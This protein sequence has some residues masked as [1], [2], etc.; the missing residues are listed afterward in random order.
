MYIPCLHFLSHIHVIVLTT[1]GY[2]Y[3]SN[4]SPEDGGSK[5][6]WNV[7]L[8]LSDYTVQHAT[9]QLSSHLSPW[10]PEIS[11]NIMVF[12]NSEVCAIVL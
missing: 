3:K 10:E 6:F 1:P 5:H 7:G 11:Q 8:I 9:R 12:E 2:M 4:H